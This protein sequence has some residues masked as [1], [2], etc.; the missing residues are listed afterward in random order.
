MITGHYL[1][2]ESHLNAVVKSSKKTVKESGYSHPKIIIFRSKQKLSTHS[3]HQLVEGDKTP[4]PAR[5]GDREKMPR[6]LAICRGPEWVRNKA[7]MSWNIFRIMNTV[8]MLGARQWRHCNLSLTSWK[9]RQAKKVITT[10]LH[11]FCKII[12]IFFHVTKKFLKK[13]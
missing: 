6:G 8:W 10:F 2:I 12:E 13:I 1:K 7:V 3:E 11:L 4:R 5:K 9:F